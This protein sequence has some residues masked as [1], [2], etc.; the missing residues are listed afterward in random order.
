MQKW[1]S[2]SIAVQTHSLCPH[3]V[4]GEKCPNFLTKNDYFVKII[5]FVLSSRAG[6]MIRRPDILG[7]RAHG[8]KDRALDST[9]HPDCQR[10]KRPRGNYLRY[11]YRRT[12][13]CE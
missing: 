13:Y 9:P 4:I 5:E 2:I 3:K 8:A 12:Q 6:A 7:N 10:R 11:R 1:V